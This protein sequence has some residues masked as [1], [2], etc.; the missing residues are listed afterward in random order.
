[1]VFIEKHASPTILLSTAQKIKI[2]DEKEHI[3]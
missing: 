3:I 1:M 2:I